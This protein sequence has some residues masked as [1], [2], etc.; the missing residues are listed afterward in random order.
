VWYHQLTLRHRKVLGMAIAALVVVGLIVWQVADDARHNALTDLRAFDPRTVKADTAIYA[1]DVPQLV[2][3]FYLNRS[4]VALPTCEASAS[5]GPTPP[6]GYFAVADRVLPRWLDHRPGVKIA[7]GVV[8]GRGFSVLLPE[9]PSRTKLRPGHL[10]ARRVSP[11]RAPRRS[12]SHCA[13]ND[14]E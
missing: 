5:V 7:T 6:T 14:A 12:P 2:L 8:N 10:R 1:V 3:A 11:E 9:S 13:A 4:V